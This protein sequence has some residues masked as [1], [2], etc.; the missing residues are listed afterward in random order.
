M[1]TSKIIPAQELTDEQIREKVAQLKAGGASLPRA[2]RDPINQPMINNWVEA[3][4]D[5]NPIYVD[6][7]AARAA[8]YPGTVAPPAMAQVWTMRGLHGVR[9]ADDPL[10]LA[11]ELFDA[12]GFT[13]VVA[14]NCDSTYHRYLSPGEEITVEA[15]LTEVVG[16]KVTA[17]GEG[18]FFTT[19]NTWKV[20]SETVA[21]MD[22][23]ILKFRPNKTV[24]TE[25]SLPVSS[26]GKEI[27]DLEP[28]KL[29][30]PSVSRDT[31][32]FWDGI[33]KHELR[34][35]KLKDGALQ[36]PPI[37]AI[38]KAATETTDYLVA[39]GTGTVFSFVVHHGPQV[40]GRTLPFI[41]ALVEIDEGVRLLGQLRGVVPSEVAIGMPVVVEFTDFPEGDRGPAWSQY[42]WRAVDAE[43]GTL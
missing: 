18:W 12:A 36:H 9:S 13:S 33:N 19:R 17:L 40:P 25:S 26:L 24:G 29:M 43:A 42:S 20:G 30:R 5:T 27:V 23:R 39:A 41:I 8:G 34:I 3:I 7:T 35:Q 1:N 31:Q 10:G 2:G 6:D 32:F 4:G 37:P 15:E 14:T 22:F 38:W 21:E 28:D 16:P 11:T